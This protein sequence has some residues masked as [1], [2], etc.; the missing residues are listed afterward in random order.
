M[1]YLIVQ[2][3]TKIICCQPIDKAAVTI[4]SASKADIQ[5]K[6]RSIA[7]FHARIFQMS[8]VYWLEPA[9]PELVIFLN[10]NKLN[11]P[12]SIHINDIVNI[13]KF[14]IYL[15]STPYPITNDVITFAFTRNYLIEWMTK[16]W[17]KHASRLLAGLLLLVAIVLFGIFFILKSSSTPAPVV[18]AIETRPISAQNDLKLIESLVHSNDL[19]SL[20]QARESL[21]EALIQTPTDNVLENLF[22]AVDEKIENFFPLNI[23]IAANESSKPV[24]NY[25]RPDKKALSEQ[26]ISAVVSEKRKQDGNNRPPEVTEFWPLRDSVLIHSNTPVV[27]LASDPDGDSLNYEW[28]AFYGKIIGQGKNVLYQTPVTQPKLSE[29]LITVVISDGINPP[30]KYFRTITILTRYPLS[31]QQKQLA[32]E[33]YKLALRYLQDFESQERA[34]EYFKKVLL[35]APDPDFAYY[36]KARNMLERLEEGK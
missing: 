35:V 16:I 12:Q 24:K 7:S 6:G 8:G 32:I 29:D 30:E 23:P 36:R 17:Y 33:F 26:K 11:K 18:Q 9:T 19:D 21:L 1:L 22:R 2:I 31:N 25:R 13:G 15:S 4:G 34:R 10:A 20:F 5:L 27:I 14:T 3:Q 28:S